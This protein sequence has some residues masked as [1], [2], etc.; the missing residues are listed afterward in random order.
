VAR[1]PVTMGCNECNEALY[2][3]RDA[4][5]AAR[6]LALV[7]ENALANG[8]IERARCALR[9]MKSDDS[10]GSLGVSTGAANAGSTRG[11]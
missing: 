1:P 7:A 2:E 4:L 5:A 6:R 10:Y 8:D 9:G 3:A 11:R